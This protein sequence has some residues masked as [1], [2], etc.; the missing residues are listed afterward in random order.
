MSATKRHKTTHEED[1]AH[2]AETFHKK[3]AVPHSHNGHIHHPTA[4]P[5]D[6]LMQEG[7]NAIYGDQKDTVDFSKLDRAK[8]R[9]TNFLLKTIGFLGVV[10]VIAWSAYY[11]YTKYFTTSEADTFILEIVAPDEIVSGDDATFEIHYK[12]PSAIPLA[13]LEIEVKLPPAY[14]LGGLNPAPSDLEALTWKI[15]TLPAGSDGTISITG[16]WLASVPSSMPIQ[17]F[18]N[19]R[20]S[21]FNAD[22]QSIK[23]AYISSFSS[24]ITSSFNGP[25]E[26]TPGEKLE[27]SLVLVNESQSDINNI[28]A[29][30]QLP[31]GFFIDPDTEGITAGDQPLWEIAVIKAGEEKEIKFTGTFAADN[32]GFQYF[33]LV[34]S[35]RGND[36][37]LLTQSK[38]QGFTDVIGSNV[39]VQLVANGSTE[40]INTE[41]DSDLRVSISIEN[42]GEAP[43]EDA[44]LLLDFQ[45]AKPFPVVWNDADLDQG[46]ITSDG[47]IWGADS[48][49]VLKKGDKKIFN[50]TFPIEASVANDKTD[51]FTIVAETTLQNLPIRSTPIKIGINSEAT[52]TVKARYYSESGA[53]LG[54]GPLPP[55]IGKE[56]SYK[57]FWSV[58]NSLHDLENIQISATLPPNVV[59]KNTISTDLGSLTYTEVNRTVTWKVAQ[60]PR[61]IGIINADF[62]IGIVPTDNDLGKF[63]KLI[64]G[65]SFKAVD[66][67]TT[68]TLQETTSTLDSELP[69]DEHASGN[70]IVA[71]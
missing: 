35:L 15:G 5:E 67:K 51:E 52:F 55:V 42:T 43:I 40:N 65:S 8:N 41:L 6:E 1:L 62:E 2:H 57:V 53:P 13:T 11:I 60:L 39:I 63:I 69:E 61:T 37:N 70:G 48:I 36:K 10:A 58:Q 17:V 27:Y 9:F 33:D 45:S 46:T 21:N 23:T 71:E 16:T 26:A 28:V 59:W 24:G 38:T 18:A 44:E 19:Y 25:S 4:K 12:N 14:Q 31:N 30:L 64:S 29:E 3:E 7:L 49:G 34:T 32:V 54:T 22:F 56:T 66:T 47:I 68:A 50:L 20:P